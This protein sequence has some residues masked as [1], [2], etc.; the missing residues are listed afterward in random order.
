MSDVHVIAMKI[1]IHSPI[2]VS[3]LNQSFNR[4]IFKPNSPIVSY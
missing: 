1:C 3:H 4:I 2:T